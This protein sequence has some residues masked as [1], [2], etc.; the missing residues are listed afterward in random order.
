[1]VL[2]LT[3][4]R[5]DICQE[6]KGKVEGVE[7]Q[8]VARFH[9]VSIQGPHGPQSDVLAIRPQSQIPVRAIVWPGL[10]TFA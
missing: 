5:F 4:P 9:R 7:I 6:G 2:I 10:C 1:M 8:I 3:L